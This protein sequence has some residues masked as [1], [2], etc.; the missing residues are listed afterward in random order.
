MNIQE[1]E[2]SRAPSERSPIGCSPTASHTAQRR[3]LLRAF[4]RVA[5]A[6]EHEGKGNATGKQVVADP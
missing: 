3:C 5:Q 1:H 2:H 6:L 4:R